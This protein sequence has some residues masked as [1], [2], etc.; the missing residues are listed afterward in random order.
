LEKKYYK[1]SDI[2]RSVHKENGTLEIYAGDKIIFKFD[3][4]I[5]ASLFANKATMFCQAFSF[6]IWFTIV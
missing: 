1:F 2:T 4:N 3:E 5:S 6:Y